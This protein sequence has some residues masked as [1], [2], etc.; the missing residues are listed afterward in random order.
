MNHL[1]TK[2]KDCSLDET[3]DL[4]QNFQKWD[5][6]TLKS[7]QRTRFPELQ[8][9]CSIIRNVLNELYSS[10]PQIQKWKR[11]AFQGRILAHSK[12]LRWFRLRNPQ[13]PI[14][15]ALERFIRHSCKVSRKR[16]R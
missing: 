10:D 12:L 8:H 14:V 3:N 7:E 11:M 4:V 5:P 16:N 13:Q 6:W 15:P 2:F 1:T 9:S